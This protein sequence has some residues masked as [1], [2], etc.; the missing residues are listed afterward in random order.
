MNNRVGAMGETV[1]AA[2]KVVSGFILN[3]S[4]QMEK[5]LNNLALA[6]KNAKL[7]IQ[8]NDNPSHI[9]LL[10]TSIAKMEAVLNQLVSGVQ[11]SKSSLHQGF[12]KEKKN[13]EIK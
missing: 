11:D 1:L 6:V 3:Y 9:E 2:K 10:E 8:Y 7:N 12:P 5:P 4:S 13:E